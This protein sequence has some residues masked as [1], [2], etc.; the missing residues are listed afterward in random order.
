M[1]NLVTVGLAAVLAAGFANAQSGVVIVDEVP[2][3]SANEAEATAEIALMSAY[4]WRGMV[5]NEGVVLQPQFTI[6]QYGVSFNVWANY[7]FSRNYIGVKNDISEIDLSLA[8]TLPLDLND[9]SF[10]IGLISY[11]FPANGSNGTN[12]K[13]TAELFAAAHWLTFRDYV[14]PSATL[15]GDVKEADGIY[16]LLDIVAP[17]EISEYLYAEVGASTGYGN[18]RYNNYYYDPAD[19]QDMGKGFSDYNIWGTISYE[20]LDNLTASLNL[21]YTG[22]YGGA[23]KNAAKQTYEAGEQFWGGVNISYDF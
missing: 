6:A 22:L 1:K 15:F 17:I 5:M 2:M 21:T 19:V 20:L 7:D 13:S 16:V 18:T 11:Q 4:V 9:V 3:A 8:Y 23:I 10:D 14:I 12:S